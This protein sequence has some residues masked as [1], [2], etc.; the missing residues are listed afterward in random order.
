MYLVQ[1]LAQR[2]VLVVLLGAVCLLFARTDY[3]A[4]KTENRAI[5]VRDLAG[6]I[7]RGIADR[8]K[9]ENVPA[10]ALADDA[11][12]LRRA[13]L[14]ITGII[15]TADRAVAFLDSKDPNKRAL[16]IDELLASQKFG[17]HMA[18]VWQGMLVPLNSDNRRLDPNPMGNWLAERFNRNQPWDKLVYDLITATGSQ[19]DNGAV[20]FFVG[21][22]TADKMTDSVTRLF[23]GIQLQC[24]QCHNHPFTSWKQTEYWG[25]AAFFM[26]VAP[27]RAQQAAKKG[28][29]PGVSESARGLG[30]KNKLPESA[31]FVPARFLTG[32][33]PK[34]PAGE[35][36][37]PVLAK[38]LTSA[39]NPFFAKA[40]VNRLWGQ[41]F[42]KG[43]VNAV[44]NMH[45]DNP[46]SH[47]EVLQALTEQFKESG[48]DVK[49]LIRAICNSE[50]YQRT[51]KPTGNNASFAT[52]FGHMSIKTLTPEQLFDCL[53]QV[54][55][56]MAGPLE[57]R[58]AK[59]VPPA[60]LKKGPMGGPR[61]QFTAFFRASDEPDPTE[62]E[63]GIPQALRL[64]NSP[65]HNRK[66]DLLDKAVQAGATP[67]QV[68]TRLY[69]GT[70]SRRPSDEER[71][72]LLA[73]VDKNGSD[74]RKA[75][76][77]LLWVLLNSSEFTL[78]H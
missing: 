60:L 10:S 22:P 77:D 36:Y 49:Y 43:F 5:A 61:A 30:K 58:L 75:Y 27:D 70:I 62:Y 11:E 47:P 66:A 76:S 7:D 55:G 29:S 78:N 42:G 57:G 20:T 28:I 1:R 67:E 31:K 39:G 33:T 59:K 21:N 26:K 2:F 3:A 71:G 19:E 48:F 34:M 12:F 25:I 45:D 24:A 4:E 17:R 6:I 65:Q 46:A 8:L 9:S 32:E 18:D 53:A 73:F 16:L 68:I 72:R 13:S 37:R 52:L 50:A 54:T 15:P 41:L 64:M 74:T 51:S 14:D 40:M 44:D 23:L 69:L 56:S 35:P 38:W 63:A